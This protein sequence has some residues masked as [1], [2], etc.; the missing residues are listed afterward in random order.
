MFRGTLIGSGSN[1][2]T[3]KG[4]GDEYETAIMYLAPHKLSMKG[5]VCPMAEK[6]G[7]IAGCLN[8]AGRG[9]MNNVQLARVRKTQRYFKDR[10]AFMAELTE[11]LERFEAYCKRKGVKPIVRLNGTSDIQFEV[12]HPV[13]RDGKRYVNVFEAF[14]AVQF[15][16]YTKIYKRVYRDLPPNYR[17]LLSYSGANKQYEHEILKAAFYTNTNIAVVFR[18]KEMRD[19][20]LATGHR[21]QSRI[22]G[23]WITRRVIDGDADDLRFNDPD[24]VIVGLYAKGSAKHDTS[25]FVVG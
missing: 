1:A 11:D 25:G 8:T 5:N 4:D 13:I 2:K 15:Y 22:A 20:L 14:P 19:G 7:C 18:S 6:A 24:G 9:G 16:D 10:A 12:A 3:I 17:L 21:L 23:W